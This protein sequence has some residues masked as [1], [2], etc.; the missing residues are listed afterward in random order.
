[1]PVGVK[2]IEVMSLRSVTGRCL[3]TSGSDSSSHLPPAPGPVGGLNSQR[4]TVASPAPVAT[5][6]L[7]SGFQA[8]TKT[9]PVCSPAR[10][11]MSSALISAIEPIRFE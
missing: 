8:Q 1:V 2:T 6:P 9:S 10:W 4:R 3:H 7:P 5:L 11:T